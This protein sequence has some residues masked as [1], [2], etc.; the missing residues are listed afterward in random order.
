MAGRAFGREAV[1][2]VQA[3][4]ESSWDQEGTGEGGEKSMGSGLY[5]EVKWIGITGGLEVGRDKAT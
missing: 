2:V 4:D 1:L 5:F 3:D